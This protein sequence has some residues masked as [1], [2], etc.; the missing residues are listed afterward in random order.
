V[1]GE[2][3]NDVSEAAVHPVFTGHE[4]ERGFRNVVS[5]FTSHT[6]QKPQNQK[7][8]SNTCFKVLMVIVPA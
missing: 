5:K 8:I 2:F 4:L 1:Q 7:T 3:T 6:V